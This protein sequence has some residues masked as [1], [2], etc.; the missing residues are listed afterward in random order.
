MQSSTKHSNN[1]ELSHGLKELIKK[2]QDEL[3][4]KE[5][6]P[7]CRIDS[8]CPPGSVCLYGKCVELFP[9]ISI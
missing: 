2:R 9:G 6:G 4:S 7:S 3:L 5:E 8:D 1:E